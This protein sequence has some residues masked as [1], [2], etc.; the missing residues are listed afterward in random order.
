MSQN[1]VV[2]KVFNSFISIFVSICMILTI[3]SVV[4]KT[5]AAQQ[6][7][8]EPPSIQGDYM[9]QYASTL[10]K[11]GLLKSDSAAVTFTDN[12]YEGVYIEGTNTD[13]EEN[14]FYI[15]KTFNFNSKTISRFR[16]D[17][18]AEYGSNIKLGCFLDGS[19]QPTATV[20]LYKQRK[21]K[22][23]DYSKDICINLET[24]KLSGTHTVSFK[25]LNSSAT[26]VKFLLRSFEFMEFSV[27]TVSFNIDESLGTVS[28]M[29]SSTDHSVECYGSMNIYVPDSFTSEY[30]GQHPDDGIYELEY[31]RG[32]GNSTWDTNRKPYKI[33][34]DTKADL[35]GMGA[36][37][38][39]VLLANYYDNS[40]LRNKITY[41][42]G[43]QL[44][45]EYTPKSE[46]VE[47]VMNGEYYGTYL[48]CEQVRVG[49]TRVNID[50]LEKN[51]ETIH[52]TDPSVISGG[53]L[54]SMGMSDDEKLNVS[55]KRNIDL[56][57]ESPTFESY[58][59]EAQ[60]N[61]IKN[62]LQETEDAIY[63]DGF[64]DSSGKSYTEYLNLQSAVDYIWL[65]EYSI[66]GD[67]FLSGST[68]LYKKRNSDADGK[69]YFGPLWD[70]DYVAW[71]STEYVDP[72]TSG[73]NVND[74]MWYSR[75]FEDRTF[76]QAFIDR[77]A[78]LKEKI[79]EL[80]KAGGQ[81]D[82]YKKRFETS[83]NYN[84]E[85]FGMSPL[86]YEDGDDII[87]EGGEGEV[88]TLTYDEEIERLRT[89]ITDRENWV[90]N[91]VNLLTPKECTITY[92]V[93]GKTYATKTAYVGKSI[94]ASVSIP[95]K[96]GYY[97]DG[98]YTSYHLTFDQY[99]EYM[100]MS[101]S[102]LQDEMDADEIAQLKT[103]G[104]SYSGEVK[105]SDS[106]PCSITL[107]AKFKSTKKAKLAKSVHIPYKTINLATD[108]TFNMGAN[109]LPANAVDSN[110]YWSSD[111]T[112]VAT[113]DDYGEVNTKLAGTAVITVQNGSGLKASCTIKVLSEEELEQNEYQEYD[114][115]KLSTKVKLKAG[116]CKAIDVTLQPVNAYLNSG[117][118]GINFESSDEKV[119]CVDNAGVIQGIK[120]GTAIITVSTVG[121][122]SDI[123][124]TCKVTVS[125][126]K[127]GVVGQKIT[128]KKVKYQISGNTSKSGYTA[129]VIG[130]KSKKLKKAT[131]VKTIKYNGRK[132]QVTE[133]GSKAFGGCKKLKKIT[134]KPKK[135][136]ARNSTFK[137]LSKKL[138]IIVPK[139][140]KQFY[141]K[142]IKCR[143][144]SQA[145]K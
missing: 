114:S 46:P 127:G 73:W 37:K 58:Y 75:L 21:K 11:D 20:T 23:W 17:A 81:L 54:L 90:D 70:F 66:N 124:A 109:V 78:D 80:T 16:I 22:S 33:K 12:N 137:K 49:K 86:S 142:M 41:W 53:Y 89:W 125:P 115:M 56:M 136:Y 110:L 99:L 31:I 95:K 50:D 1:A 5:A 143:K 19:T 36:N 60:Y 113:V 59:N 8:S 132:Y 129:K 94:N 138:K 7:S 38:H 4:P 65:Q 140:T 82:I 79:D 6:D 134:I 126:A 26:Q 68:Y 92:N 96:K 135:L 40:M 98:W 122:Q 83:V 87:D 3:C 29:N 43:Q 101:E 133:I 44:G 97:F 45:M 63:G 74:R 15:D 106:A 93:D 42:L 128:K 119:A 116:E 64:K 91:H 105:N 111:N 10:L 39:W 118:E 71:G 62:Y 121:D 35:L 69:L 52:S 51:D 9:N 123:K 2:K 18:L 88:V 48:L 76:A 141:K 32:R 55:T 72:N 139:N 100:N 103:N 77:W 28:E 85:K 102:D 61:Y 24:E 57:L 108:A 117:Y 120:S 13:L 14:G 25:V 145:K 130:L 104:Y 131:I 30:T 112:A 27:P 144:I 67:A 107:T 84:I 47:V 34:L